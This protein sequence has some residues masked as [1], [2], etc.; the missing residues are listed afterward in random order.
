[1]NVTFLLEQIYN[2]FNMIIQ[3]DPNINPDDFIYKTKFTFGTDLGKEFLAQIDKDVSVFPRRF[4][5]NDGLTMA[6]VRDLRRRVG[7]D[8]TRELVRR[9][10]QVISKFP[11]E[12]LIEFKQYH[13]GPEWD[14]KVL[15]ITP[16]WLKGIGPNE[17]TKRA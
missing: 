13:C 15:D 6:K 16:D 2:T 12:N 3:H 1:M 17:R 7:Q 14:A 10:H 5:Y 9:Q 4:N 11:G 8:K